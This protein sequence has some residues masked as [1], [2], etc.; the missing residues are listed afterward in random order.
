MIIQKKAVATILRDQGLQIKA[1]AYDAI[2]RDVTGQ[3]ETWAKWLASTG[4]KRINPSDV[5]LGARANVTPTARLVE[6]TAKDA[7]KK[8]DDLNGGCTR[9]YN[10]DPTALYVA[11]VVANHVRGTVEDKVRAELLTHNLL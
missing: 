2:N 10:L 3:I 9:C 11:Q 4:V 1:E 6:A 8:V 7:I 5:S